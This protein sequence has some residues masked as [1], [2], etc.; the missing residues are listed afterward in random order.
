L[1]L[2]QA[3]KGGTVFARVPIDALPLGGETEK[4][5]MAGDWHHDDRSWIELLKEPAEQRR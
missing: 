5:P 2:Y 4:E 3:A 1:V